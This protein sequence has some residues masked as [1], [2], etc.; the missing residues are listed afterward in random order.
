MRRL[1][2]LVL[3][4]GILLLS[5]TV[6]FAA[7][8]SDF[9][10]VFVSD[11]PFLADVI[12]QFHFGD[13]NYIFPIKSSLS[14]PISS[15]VA[16]KG[17]LSWF[18]DPNLYYRFGQFYISPLGKICIRFSVFMKSNYAYKRF[19]VSSDGFSSKTHFHHGF[20]YSS[21]ENNILGS[22]E[23]TYDPESKYFLA[24]AGF[25][26]DS[27]PFCYPC[28]G[29]DSQAVYFPQDGLFSSINS[30]YISELSELNFVSDMTSV[31]FV[32]VDVEEYIPPASSKYSLTINYQYSNGDSALDPVV[33]PL[34]PGAE[35][36]VPSPAVEGYAP[37]IPL[38]TGTMP[39]HDL[40]VTVTYTRAFYPLTVQYRYA[41]GTKALDDAAY[42]YPSGFVYDIPTPE[43]AGYVPDKPKVA[44][45]M[46]GNALTETVTYTGKPFTLTVRYQYEN[47]S[48]AASD[49]QEQLLAGAS[50]SVPS[51]V[52]QG[53]MPDLA[54]AAGVMP[55]KDLL[56]TVIYKADAGSGGEGEGP[57]GSG[58]GGSEGDDPF[59]LPVQPPFSGYD[60][61][62]IP[63]LPPWSG[64]D[65]FKINGLPPYSYDPFMIPGK[66]GGRE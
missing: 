5:V 62:V 40:T 42:Q 45:I 18:E 25:G 23:L 33:Q 56:V 36:S 50:Y 13:G 63:G 9:K 48:M 59:E 7:S 32:D 16:Y 58:G 49:H 51:P 24:R 43:L 29:M 2:A 31:S 11:I 57:G 4:I 17:F 52:L 46:P 21:Y 54:A 55:A 61:F 15:Y 44:G 1:L 27:L 3:A 6:G 37:D 19:S 28:L 12:S 26:N 30:N 60:P 35:Y 65:P 34:E 41:D 20:S 22:L 66:E 53:Y 64:Y 38:V 14:R 8:P 47:G 10:H 39:E